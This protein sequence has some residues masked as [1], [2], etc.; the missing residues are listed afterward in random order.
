VNSRAS[1]FSIF[2]LILLGVGLL[3]TIGLQYRTGLFGEN[4]LGLA[5]LSGPILLLAMAVS[6]ASRPKRV[7]TDA[8]SPKI[9]KGGSVA[10]AVTGVGLVMLLVGGFPWLYTPLFFGG[11]SNS[12]SGMLGT[13]IWLFIGLPGL[14]IA[15]IGLVNMR[16]HR[17]ARIASESDCVAV[18]DRNASMRPASSGEVSTSGPREGPATNA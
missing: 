9:R 7:G 13:I 14:I 8:A 1:R 12:S 4:P 10:G 6:A 5:L 18:A 11:E 16:T 3:L 2:D 17:R 15:A